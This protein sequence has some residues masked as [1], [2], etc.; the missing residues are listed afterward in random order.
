[1]G[2]HEDMNTKSVKQAVKIANWLK[3]V[4]KIK[5]KDKE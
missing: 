2:L 3:I 1:M 4:R 5:I